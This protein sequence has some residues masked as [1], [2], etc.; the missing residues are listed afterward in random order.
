M[1]RTGA[2][3]AGLVMWLVQPLYLVAELAAVSR[4]AAP[5][6]LR[7]NTISDLGATTCTAIAYP[8]GPVE[9]CSPWHA[10]VNAAFVVFGL[11]L[12]AGAVLIR[13]A[14]QARRLRTW[15][16]ILWVL[17]GLSSVGT[18]LVPLDLDLELHYLVSLPVFLAQPVA[19]LLTGLLLRP[20]HPALGWTGLLAGVLTLAAGV[21]FTVQVGDPTGGGLLERVILW[22][23]YPWTALAA[24]VLLRDH[25]RS[26]GPRLQ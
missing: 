1:R 6:S 24:V 5:Y 14:L 7:D 22:T 20:D 8:Y 13:A 2:V 25:E 15:A 26:G 16:V 11:L 17:A 23:A 21:V 18:G 4:V 9:V 19:L 3:T 10:L 12:A